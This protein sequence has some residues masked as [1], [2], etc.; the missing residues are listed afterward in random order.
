M[1]TSIRQKR[2]PL[3]SPDR[4]SRALIKRSSIR[5]SFASL[6]RY[7]AFTCLTFSTAAVCWRSWSC[8][9]YSIS[10]SASL[11][12]CAVCR[13]RRAPSPVAFTAAS[14]GFSSCLQAG[15]DPSPTSCGPFGGSLSKICASATAAVGSELSDIENEIADKVAKKLVI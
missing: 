13:R 7:L 2:N 12:S 3:T 14:S 5:S 6:L 8:S 11:I 9:F 10:C 15:N 4:G 1:R